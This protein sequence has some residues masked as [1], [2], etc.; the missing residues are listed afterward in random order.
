MV[1]S[2]D[3]YFELMKELTQGE[4]ESVIRGRFNG[5]IVHIDDAVRGVRLTNVLPPSVT[6]R[7][8]AVRWIDISALSLSE[9][10][11]FREHV[12]KIQQNYKT[13]FLSPYS[14]KGKIELVFDSE[15]KADSFMDVFVHL[16]QFAESV[17]PQKVGKIVYIRYRTKQDK[18]FRVGK[19]LAI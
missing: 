15:E 9:K 1:I 11:R 16:A 3:Y 4:L 13:T 6:Q 2:T 12:T 5:M 10:I 14:P 18:V 17:V 7:G 8:L 19:K